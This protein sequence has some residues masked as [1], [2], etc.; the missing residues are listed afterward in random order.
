MAALAALAAGCMVGPDYVRP[1]APS[2]AAFKES[3]G[4]KAAQPRDDA[5]RGKWWEVFG[6]TDLDAL[7]QQVD[8]SNQTIQA[9]EARVREARAATPGRAR[10]IVPRR[11]RQRRGAAQLA[12]HRQRFQRELLRRR[13]QLQ[14]RRST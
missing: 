1:D 14:R 3:A 10:R 7:E 8:A 11:Q 4:W 6:D 5:P 2:S 9:A 12:R 13:Q